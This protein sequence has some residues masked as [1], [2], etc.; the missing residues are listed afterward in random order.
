MGNHKNTRSFP[1]GLN[2]KKHRGTK[3]VERGCDEMQNSSHGDVVWSQPIAMRPGF[4]SHEPMLLILSREVRTTE[5]LR[6]SRAES[7]CC[8]VKPR[9]TADI[10]HARPGGKGCKETALRAFKKEHS[11]FHLAPRRAGGYLLS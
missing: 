6:H 10:K 3:W 4:I 9:V 5:S 8:A 7:S 2:Y 1:K 11:V